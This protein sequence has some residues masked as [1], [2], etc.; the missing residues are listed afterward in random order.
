[1]RPALAAAL[2][3]LTLTVPA[4]AVDP[5]YQGDME[6]LAQMLGSLYFLDPLC[7]HDKVDWRAQMQ[8]LINLDQPDDDR[9][10]RI[11][12]AFNDGYTAYARLY[13]VCT[14]SAAQSLNRLLSDAEATARNIQSHYAE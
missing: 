7:Q 4:R 12:G 8:E 5:P 11:A 13:R 3:C 2:L 9:R 1:M 6:R 14:V 10:Q